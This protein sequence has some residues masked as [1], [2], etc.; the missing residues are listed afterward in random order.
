[1]T[2]TLE[3][4]YDFSSPYAYIGHRHAAAVA[5]EAGATFVPRPFLLGGLFKSLNS[6]LVPIQEAT[7]QKRRVLEQDIFRQAELNDLPLQWP[8]R[9][10]MNTILA[11]RVALQ[12]EG[13]AHLDVMSALFGAYWADDRDISDA[14]VV[15]AV[16][17]DLGI[18]ADACLVGCQ[19]PEIKDALRINT[20]DALRRGAIGA[21]AFFVGDLHVW[22]QDRLLDVVP[23]MLRGWQPQ[24]G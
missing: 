4:F 5:A 16:I 7:P 23:R 20:E 12:F 1:M 15:H 9:F 21:P 11:L 19:R 2:K 3:M 17:S 18:D 13:Q 6:A 24:H 22:G 14:V 8:S 10:P